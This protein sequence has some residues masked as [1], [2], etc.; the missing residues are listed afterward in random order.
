MGQSRESLCEDEV[1]PITGTT[2]AYSLAEEVSPTAEMQMVQPHMPM[3]EESESEM[4]QAAGQMVQPMMQPHMQMQMVQPHMEEESE[5]EVESQQQAQRAHPQ[6]PHALQA[7]VVVAATMATAAT[8]PTATTTT[9]AQRAMSAPPMTMS[10]ASKWL[11]LV[12]STHSVDSDEEGFERAAAE[13]AW[14]AAS[15][16]A[17]ASELEVQITGSEWVAPDDEMQSQTEQFGSKTQTWR[18]NKQ[19]HDHDKMTLRFNKQPHDPESHSKVTSRF[20][21]QPH[22]PESHSKIK[23]MTSRFTSDGE[24]AILFVGQ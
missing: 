3:E 18:F 24:E 8:A 19:P 21:K 12:A 14:A 7:P 23:M 10:A 17:T 16:S 5:S 4:M 22:D 6:A 1:S 15:F 2:A 13:S 11:D 9:G 20:N